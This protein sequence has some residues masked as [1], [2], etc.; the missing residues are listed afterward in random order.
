MIRAHVPDRQ[1]SI[2]KGWIGHLPDGESNES[3]A[4]KM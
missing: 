2:E 4:N 1:K 3:Q